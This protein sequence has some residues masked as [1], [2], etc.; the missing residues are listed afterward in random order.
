M[1]GLLI[2]SESIYTTVVNEVLAPY[3]KEQTWAVKAQLMGTPEREATRI[4]LSNLWPPREGVKEDFGPDC[5]FTIDD[6]LKGRN[7]AIEEAFTRVKPL[8]GAERLVRHLAAH[9]IPFALATGSKRKNYEIKSGANPSLFEP[10]QDRGICGDDERLKRGKPT[11]DIFALAAREA[12]GDSNHWRQR[13]REP[14]PQADGTFLGGEKE[15]LVFEDAMPGVQAA[16]AAGM[17][18][19]WVPD[20][21]LRELL[22]TKDLGASQTLNSLLDFKPEE[23][24][25]P[26]FPSDA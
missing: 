18:V 6:F 20:P 7:Q 16:R 22:E 4:L 1:D 15:I 21:N 13:V 17:H 14:G 23:W 11:A 5:P 19:V 12:L 3:G 2:D 8:P 9:K 25:L 10:F 24:G 26:P